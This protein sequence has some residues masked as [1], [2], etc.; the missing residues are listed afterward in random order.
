MPDGEEGTPPPSLATPHGA[1]HPGIVRLAQGAKAGCQKLH[2]RQQRPQ[3][4]RAS[5]QSSAGRHTRHTP[6]GHGR[7][8]G[9]G[10]DPAAEGQAGS[11]WALDAQ[12][13]PRQVRLNQAML[14]SAWGRLRTYAQYK[15]PKNN[16]LFLVVPPHH[17]SQE[18]AACGHIHPDNRLSQSRFV[19]RRCEHADHADHN[20][21]RVIARRG[22][23]SVIGRCQPKPQGVGAERPEPSRLCVVTTPVETHVRR[24]RGSTPGVHGSSKPETAPTTALAV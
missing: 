18:C 5:G 9:A 8:Q 2:L 7:P 12:W 11:G 14:H 13:R 4:L 16:V 17:S 19:C 22:V 6:A 20:A 10:H 1:A 24:E 3:G 21:S 15:T 23:Q